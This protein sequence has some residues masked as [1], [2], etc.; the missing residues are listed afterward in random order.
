MVTAAVG[1]DPGVPGFTTARTSGESAVLWQSFF[2]GDVVFDGMPVVDSTAVDSANI[3]TSLLR[4][5]LVMAKLDAS[6]NWVDYDP[7]A[8][9]GSQEARGILVQEI[10]LL[11]YSTGS[12]A[13]RLNG[14]IV[15]AGKAKANQLINLDQ[16]ARQQLNRRGFSFDD[17]AWLGVS[18]FRRRVTKAADYTVVAADHG[19]LFQAITGAVNFTLPAIASSLGFVAEF[20]NCVD[21]NMTV[22]SADLSAD[23]VAFSTASHKIGG[24]VMVEC[25]Y[26]GS[27]LKWIITIKNASTNV[28]TIAT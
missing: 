24:R 1:F 8:T 25:V 11:D 10:N 4:P 13:T 21:A 17:D 26:V 20:L 6:G 12:A 22:T 23:S 18:S 19:T 28:A 7:T 16:Q 5:G 3:P 15:V 14:S 2:Q 27:T 9:D